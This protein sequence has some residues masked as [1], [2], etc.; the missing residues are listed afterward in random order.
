MQHRSAAGA[1]SQDRNPRRFAGRQIHLAGDVIRVADNDKNVV[2]F[3]KSQDFTPGTGLGEVE[4]CLVTGEVPGRGGEGEIQVFHCSF[5][6]LM[7]RSGPGGRLILS[8]AAH[9]R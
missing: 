4:E 9:F 2:W 8:N 5:T 7:Y 3:P 1:A 6:M